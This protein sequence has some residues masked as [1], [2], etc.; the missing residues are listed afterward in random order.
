MAIALARNGRSYKTG[1]RNWL[2]S[3]G[4][5]EGNFKD[6]PEDMKTLSGSQ[7]ALNR[8]FSGIQSRL[9]LCSPMDC[10]LPGSS[11]HGIFQ[12]RILDGVPFPTPGDLPNSGLE[13]VSLA[14]SALA[15]GFFI[16]SAI[17]EAQIF[18]SIY[19]SFQAKTFFQ[20][21]RH[22]HMYLKRDIL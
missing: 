9:T 2:K 18:T 3:L 17:W 21:V 14:S 19:L 13:P 6:D 12:A 22:F 20:I 16:T 7:Q 15:D 10:S 8:S 4:E 11:I 5:E 1:F